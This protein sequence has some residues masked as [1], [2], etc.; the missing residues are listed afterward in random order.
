MLWFE[1][2][3]TNKMFQENPG[4][5]SS[6][7]YDGVTTKLQQTKLGLYSMNLTDSL[8]EPLALAVSCHR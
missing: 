3:L 6:S 1:R 5:Q 7:S 8:G 2:C 4:S